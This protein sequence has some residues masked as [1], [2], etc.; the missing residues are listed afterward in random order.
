MTTSMQRPAQD[1]DPSSLTRTVR[2]AVDGYADEDRPLAAYAT[3]TGVYNA[4]FVALLLIARSRR[5]TVAPPAGLGDMALM[6]IATHRLARLIAKDFV[7][8]FLRAPF[9]RYEGK[10]TGHSETEETYRGSGMQRAIGEL[11]SCPY[12]I[13]QWIAP[14]LWFGSLLA[15]APTRLITRIFTTVAVADTLHL[16]YIRATKAAKS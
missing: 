9:T 5:D 6:G 3:L 16:A 7:T 8:G 1:K 12:C 10:G 2:E 4:G 15:P 13:A 14:A 11:I